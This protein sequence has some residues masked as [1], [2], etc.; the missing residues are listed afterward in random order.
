MWVFNTKLN[1]IYAPLL[2]CCSCCGIAVSSLAQLYNKRC[3][4]DAYHVKTVRENLFQLFLKAFGAEECVVLLDCNIFV[5]L[6]HCVCSEN[7]GAF[8]VMILT[9]NRVLRSCKLLGECY[10]FTIKPIT[11]PLLTLKGGEKMT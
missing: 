9:V 3:S 8:W 11:S 1:C 5:E 6:F 4:R 7:H 10:A 2:L